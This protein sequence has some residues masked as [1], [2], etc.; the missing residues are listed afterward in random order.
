[1]QAVEVPDKS[2]SRLSG[3]LGDLL[4]L[5]QDLA[6]VRE[7]ASRV[8]QLDP[9]DPPDPVLLRALWGS[10][11]VAYRRCFTS[12]RGHGRVKRTRLKVTDEL[13][14]ALEPELYETHK[15]ALDT[16]NQHVAHRVSDFSQVSISLLMENLP[17]GPPRIIGIGI[18]SAFLLGPEPGQATNLAKI[19][20]R[21]EATMADQCGQKQAELLTAANQG[22]TTRFLPSLRAQVVPGTDSEG[23]ND[24]RQ[25][26]P[27]GAIKATSTRPS[28]K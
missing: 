11:V 19:A 24:S 23:K 5:H 13:V 1:M 2:V 22:D 28:R 9:I 8:A 15:M 14:E 25:H 21:L 26:Y 4:S 3:E 18:L 7:T 16:A 27:D 17:S 6:F 12:G 20:G 10:A